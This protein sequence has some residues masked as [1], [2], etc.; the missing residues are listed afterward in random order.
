MGLKT[1]D[2]AD[3]GSTDPAAASALISVQGGWRWVLDLVHGMLFQHFLQDCEVWKLLVMNRLEG[4][5]YKKVVKR[6]DEMI[7]SAIWQR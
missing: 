3:L 4:G 5:R 1:A 7:R 2:E 6:V